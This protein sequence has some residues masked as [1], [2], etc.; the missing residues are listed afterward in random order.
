[1]TVR[2]QSVSEVVAG[3]RACLPEPHFTAPWARS[4][5][6]ELA[7]RRTSQDWVGGETD[8]LVFASVKP[9]AAS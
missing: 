4:P 1:M 6:L 5:A 3:S 2:P 9:S 8:P 7:L